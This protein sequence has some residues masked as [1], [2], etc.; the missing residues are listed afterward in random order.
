[1]EGVGIDVIQTCTR[2]GLPFDV[3]PKTEII[4]SGLILV[5]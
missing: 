3:P 4:W 1:M 5:D 2:A